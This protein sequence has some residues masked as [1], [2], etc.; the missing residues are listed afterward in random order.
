MSYTVLSDEQAEQFLNQ[1]F[2][3]ISGCFDKADIQDW[4]DQAFKRLGYQPDAPKTW[5][6]ARVQLLL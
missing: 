4:I 1:G 3:K 2:V 5:T 6:E